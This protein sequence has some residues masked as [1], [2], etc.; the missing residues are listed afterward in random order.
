MGIVAVIN[1]H[2]NLAGNAILKLGGMVDKYEGDAIVAYW[3]PPF[4][5]ANSHARLACRA[6]LKHLE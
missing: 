1:E 5:D 6:A 3:S 2:Y 4:I